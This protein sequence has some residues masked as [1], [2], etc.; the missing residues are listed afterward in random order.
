MTNKKLVLS[1]SVLTLAIAPASIAISCGSE[2]STGIKPQTFTAQELSYTGTTITINKDATKFDTEDHSLSEED[3][4]KMGNDLLA[5]EFGILENETFR[6]NWDT[7]QTLIINGATPITISD[8]NGVATTFQEFFQNSTAWDAL[9]D[10]ERKEA[11]SIGV[12]S[13]ER[14]NI[15]ITFAMWLDEGKLNWNI[16]HQFLH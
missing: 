16:K 2:E 4:K 11:E 13:V 9:D 8:L 1:L 14:F 3:R 5:W 7:A 12:N 10:S 15:F 6:D